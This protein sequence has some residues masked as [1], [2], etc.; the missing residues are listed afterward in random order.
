MPQVVEPQI[1]DPQELRCPRKG[2]ADR[3]R[4]VGKDSDRVFGHRLD[5]RQRWIGQVAPDVVTNLLAGVLH[6]A[7]E[8]PFTVV[9][10]V[11]PR[12][13]GDLLLPPR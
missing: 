7:H 12:D 9:V 13:P 4:G 8:N 5:D 1:L 11:R 10:E 3:V 2:R 6:V